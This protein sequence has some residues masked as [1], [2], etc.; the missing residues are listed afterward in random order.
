MLDFDPHWKDYLWFYEIFDGDSGR[1]LGASHQCGWT[2][3][4]AKM[5]HD[6]GINCRLPQTPRTPT[7][8]A[9]H[10]F[11][12]VFTR[13]RRG[14]QSKKP[15]GLRRSSTSRSIGARSDYWKSAPPSDDGDHETHDDDDDT[16]SNGRAW[17][18]Y[19]EDGNT[20]KEKESAD[21]HVH[22]YVQDQLKRLMTPN[23]PEQY[24]DEIE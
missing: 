3:L 6:T 24:E 10:Y 8:A 13:Q 17:T 4:M 14:S 7:A 15:S 22:K 21:E 9:S 16:K 23:G 12:D 19:K 18:I 11:D 1:G 20:N 2:G 5:I